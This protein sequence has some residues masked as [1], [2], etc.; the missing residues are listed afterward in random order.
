SG[1]SAKRLVRD[2]EKLV[3]PGGNGTELE[4]SS[5]RSPTI[6]ASG[7]ASRSGGGPSSAISGKPIARLAGRPVLI[8]AGKHLAGAAR[9][10]SYTPLARRAG[11]RGLAYAIAKPLAYWNACACSAGAI[12]QATWGRSSAG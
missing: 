1:S 5:R 2:I 4:R 3:S 6:A 8:Q 10:S 7:L 11:S 9:A 12:S